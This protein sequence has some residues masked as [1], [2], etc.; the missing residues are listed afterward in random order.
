MPNTIEQ[1][2]LERETLLAQLKSLDRLRR[3]S[4]SRQVYAKKQG[5]QDH[6]QGPYFVLQGF[7]KGTKFSRRVSAAQAE[8]VQ[9]QVGN[10]KR[11]QDLADQCITVT[12]QITQL[13]EAKTDGKKNF[14]RRKSKPDASRKPKHS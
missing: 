8:Q 11:F 1:L 7:H 13:A 9:R 4:L 10:F 5:G 14:S 2:T 3:G 12:D 6:T